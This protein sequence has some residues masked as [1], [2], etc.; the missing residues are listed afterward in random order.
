MLQALF[1]Q[2]VER[3]VFAVPN[4]LL[5]AIDRGGSKA[6]T[7]AVDIPAIFDLKDVCPTVDRS[8]PSSETAY[9]T[10]FVAYFLSAAGGAVGGV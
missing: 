2:P 5:I 1:G 7:T 8:L 6:V 10:V 4:V 9:R 3:R